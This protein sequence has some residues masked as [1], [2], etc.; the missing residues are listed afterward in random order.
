NWDVQSNWYR[1][2]RMRPYIREIGIK[3]NDKIIS[4]PDFSFNTSLYLV[5]QKGWTN[6]SNYNKKEDIE[7]LID[8]GAKYLFI[9]NPELLSKEFLH[10]FLINKV[11]S[12]EGI[13]IFKLTEDEDIN[14]S[15]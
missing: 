15:N 9:S 13:E 12:F 3:E 7:N 14:E 2:E 6:F 1:F 8:K 4:L 11:G 5:G 10:S